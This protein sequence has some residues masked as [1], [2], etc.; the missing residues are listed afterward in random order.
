MNLPRTQSSARS[1]QILSIIAG[2]ASY[3]AACEFIP[4]LTS[5]RYTV[6][7]LH[8]SHYGPGATVQVEHTSLLHI[9]RKQLDHFLRFI[10]SPHIVQD[11]PFGERVLVLSTGDTV[12]VPNVVRIMIPQR[13]VQQY[14]N[15]CEETNFTPF[16]ERTMLRILSSCTASVR[17]SLQG[18]DYFAADGSKAFDDL[19][20]VVD[21]VS[22]IGPGE[23]W[24]KNVQESLKAGKMYLK[25]DFKILLS[26][27][28]SF[29][30]RNDITACDF[31]LLNFTT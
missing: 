29:V 7:S 12:N 19:A 2:V 13:I 6:A 30:Q 10:T 28:N 16:S 9:K 20:N 1:R 14:P 31:I 5:Y 4:G 25:G 24:A 11:L 23:E 15:F 8:R 18:L 17:K 26:F 27:F 3:K 21:D 22:V